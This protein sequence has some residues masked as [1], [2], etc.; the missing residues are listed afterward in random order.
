MISEQ[1]ITFDLDIE[2]KERLREKK[3]VVY[4]LKWTVETYLGYPNDINKSFNLAI[5]KSLFNVGISCSRNNYEYRNGKLYNVI[6]VHI[7]L[8]RSS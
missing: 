6:S 3:R 5:D 8:I 1:N 7:F 2:P 4:P